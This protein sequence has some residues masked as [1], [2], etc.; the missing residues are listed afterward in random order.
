MSD[1]DLADLTRYGVDRYGH[2]RRCHP[3]RLSDGSM[4]VALRCDHEWCSANE[5]VPVGAR[6]LIFGGDE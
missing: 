5:P 1:D 4:L 6:D 2:V 3:Y